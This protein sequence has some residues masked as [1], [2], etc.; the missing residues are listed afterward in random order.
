MKNSKSKTGVSPNLL[1]SFPE[2]QSYQ[3]D[4]QEFLTELDEK[5]C[6]D[7]F[8]GEIKSLMKCNTCKSTSTKRD[9]MEDLSLSIPSTGEVNLEDSLKKHFRPKVLS[10]D[11]CY[12]CA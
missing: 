4:P 1:K 5:K 3:Q 10:K 9:E 12:Y 6:N 11:N 7:I 2:F 8:K